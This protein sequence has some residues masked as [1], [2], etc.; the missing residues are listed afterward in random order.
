MSRHVVQSP[1]WGDFKTQ[2][3][4]QAVRIGEIQ[5]TK[6]HMPFTDKF[7]G[8]CPKVDPTL[9]DFEKLH[10]SLEENNCVNAN[11]DVP[12]VA[13]DIQEAQKA[14]EIFEKNGC[15]LS[16]KDQFAKSN[17]LLDI[18]KSEEEL[19]AN[20]H[21]KHRYNIKYAQKQGVVVKDAQNLQ[22]FDVFWDLYESTS[23]RQKYYIRPK[24]Y[25]RSIWEMFKSRNMVH[26]LATYYQDVPLA[27]WLLFVYENVLYY[28]YGGSSEQHKN[29]HGST[30]LGWETILLGKKLDCHTFDMWGAGQDPTDKND[31]WSGFT[32]FKLKYG[33]KYITYMDSYDYVVNSSVYKMFGVA[34]EFRWKVLKLIK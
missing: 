21:N 8:Y 1:Q 30:Y 10:K 6:H 12:N 17:V 33:G 32:N 9:I 34:N 11:F 29:L 23:V 31:P 24:N 22:D 18:S 27:S 2:Y 3:G 7:Y 26:I 25:Y 15:V 14:K 20:M 19:L 5:Y 13:A 16:P 4:T 28:P